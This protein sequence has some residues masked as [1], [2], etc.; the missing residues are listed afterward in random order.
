MK[1]DVMART[2]DFT[3]AYIQSLDDRK[4]HRASAG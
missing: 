1:P 4:N 2:Y 3:W